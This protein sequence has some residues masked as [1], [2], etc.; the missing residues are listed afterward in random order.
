ML[1]LADTVGFA[2][3]HKLIH[4]NHLV[5]L[6]PF[7]VHPSPHDPLSSS[8]RAVVNLTAA[9]GTLATL[10][11]RSNY[12]HV[13]GSGQ[14]SCQNLIRGLALRNLV[15]HSHKCLSAPWVVYSL[16]EACWKEVA[17]SSGT[18]FLFPLSFQSQFAYTKFA[19]TEDPQV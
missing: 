3:C 15:H 18:P 8:W 7:L 1:S 13:V 12:K 16:T 2:L 5:F 11:T 10:L 6:H 19:T 17:K 14:P 9:P 4:R